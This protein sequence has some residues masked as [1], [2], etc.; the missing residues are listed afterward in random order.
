MRNA[1]NQFQNEMRQAARFDVDFDTI[2]EN[3]SDGEF[4][5]KIGNVSASG[6]LLAGAT[7]LNK[8]DRV[9]V[10]MPVVGRI[11]A[12]L[13]WKQDTRAGFK[14][15]RLVRLPDFMAMVAAIEQNKP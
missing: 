2:F 9:I 11:E 14:F 4:V 3:S 7:A 6:F 15:E 12:Y 13:V 10:R 5:A 8:G 1:G